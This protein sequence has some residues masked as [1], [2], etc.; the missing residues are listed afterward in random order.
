MNPEWPFGGRVRCHGQ[1]S[2]RCWLGDILPREGLLKKKN[3]SQSLTGFFPNSFKS[4]FFQVTVY[5]KR[6]EFTYFVRLVS[7]WLG[8]V[9][10][11]DLPEC[12]SSPS[13]QLKHP[14]GPT[15]SAAVYLD[16]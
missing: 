11:V 3:D 14:A 9:A 1:C 6:V 16:I 4:R 7:P 15:S 12:R 2:S 10:Q 8:Q 5:W 13:S